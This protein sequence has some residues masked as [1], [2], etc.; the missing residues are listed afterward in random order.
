MN[1]QVELIWNWFYRI[2]F[3]FLEHLNN[4]LLHIYKN[5]AKSTQKMSYYGLKFLP[6]DR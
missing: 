3:P 4:V 1:C 5:T 6:F 2:G